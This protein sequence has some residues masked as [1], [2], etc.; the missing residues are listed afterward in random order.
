[1]FLLD[2][3]VISE[4]RSRK[5]CHPQVAA[6]QSQTPLSSCWLSVVTLL[7]IRQGISQ[8]ELKDAP[9]AQVLKQWLEAQVKPS[10]AERILPVSS[11]LAERAGQIAALRT[12][13]LADCLIA[14][15]ALEHKLTLATRNVADFE[16]IAGL[17]FVNPWQS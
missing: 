16:D 2:S 13:S 4:L 12:H 11:A 17:K 7:E 14:A 10:F 9:F 6:W 5:R 15:T 1:M 8:V 3:N